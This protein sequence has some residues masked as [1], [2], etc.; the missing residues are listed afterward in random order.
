[1]WKFS[2][3]HYSAPT[4]FICWSHHRT[5]TEADLL[6]VT[7]LAK[8][9]NLPASPAHCSG[10]MSAESVNRKSARSSLFSRNPPSVSNS[11]GEGTLL[12]NNSV[13]SLCRDHVI[14]IPPLAHLFGLRNAG[15]NQGKRRLLAHIAPQR[16]LRTRP[17]C[18]AVRRVLAGRDGI[19]S[20]MVFAWPSRRQF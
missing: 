20:A 16:R 1:M 2:D 15:E 6:W 19:Y 8:L 17:K 13:H 10:R 4:H 12:G 11:H 3:G 14:Q 7:D 5:Q 18:V 9:Q